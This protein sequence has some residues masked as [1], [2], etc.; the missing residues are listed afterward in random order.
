MMILCFCSAYRS[1]HAHT[2]SSCA[3]GGAIREQGRVPGIFI[4]HHRWGQLLIS[5]PHIANAIRTSNAPSSEAPQVAQ[6]QGS[7]TVKQKRTQYHPHACPPLVPEYRRRESRK[8]D[9]RARRSQVKH[10]RWREAREHQQSRNGRHSTI[11]PVCT[12]LVPAYR[13]RNVRRQYGRATRPQV[14][15]DRTARTAEQDRAGH[16]NSIARD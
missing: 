14:D 4:R 8:Q 16:S 3:V 7:Q 12:P 15:T 2:L 5:C 13:R 9:G 11:A 10:P 6:G 1:R